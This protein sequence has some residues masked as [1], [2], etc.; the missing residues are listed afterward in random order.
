MPASAALRAQYDAHPGWTVHRHFDNL[1]VAVQG[2][3]LPSYPTLRRYL[4]AQDMHRQARQARTSAGALAARDRLEQL[5]VR[6]YEVEHVNA[7]WHFD[8]HHGSRK[9]LTATMRCQVAH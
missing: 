7:L 5:E 8:F 3:A 9:V 2:S 1:K 6:S 4:L